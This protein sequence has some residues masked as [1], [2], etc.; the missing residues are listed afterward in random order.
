MPPACRVPH[1]PRRRDAMTDLSTPIKPSAM[2]T[3]EHSARPI[4]RTLVIGLIAFLTVVDLFATQAILPSL[5]RPTASRRR[6]WAWP[7]TPARSAWRSPAW[8]SRFFSRAHRPAAR[9]PGQPDA[10]GDS[11][12][13][14]GDRARSCHLHRRCGSLQGLCMAIRVHV[15]TGLSGRAMQRRGHR[16]RLCRLYHRQRRQQ[17]RSAG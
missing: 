14:A 6:R 3:D 11:D 8:P 9:H 17:S 12:G 16:R 10:A 5:A 1:L 7:S 13:A 15:D 4:L 2:A